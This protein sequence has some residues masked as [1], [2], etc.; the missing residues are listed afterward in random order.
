MLCIRNLR[1]TYRKVFLWIK[2]QLVPWGVSKN[3]IETALSKYLW[4]S[5]LPMKE[6]VLIGKIACQF[7]Y[8]RTHRLAFG[9]A[10]QIA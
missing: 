8:P 5:Q 1:C 3:Y 7:K 6:V 9:S 4:K 2:L 10:H